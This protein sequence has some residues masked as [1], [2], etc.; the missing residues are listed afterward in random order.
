MKDQQDDAEEAVAREPRG[1]Q[2]PRVRLDNT[3]IIANCSVQIG[4]RL[5]SAGWSPRRGR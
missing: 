2:E 1:D 4:A 5:A 3:R